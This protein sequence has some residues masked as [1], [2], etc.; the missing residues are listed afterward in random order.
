VL[1]PPRPLG[2]PASSSLPGRRGACAPRLRPSSGIG[3]DRKSARDLAAPRRKRHSCGQGVWPGSLPLRTNLGSG[4]YATR[5]EAPLFLISGRLHLSRTHACYGRKPG[6]DGQSEPAIASR[7]T[8]ECPAWLP[9][10]RR[11]VAA[12][13]HDA[14][15]RH[16]GGSSPCA[17]AGR[18]R[19]RRARPGPG[20]RGVCGRRSRGARGQGRQRRTRGRLLEAVVHPQAAI[21]ARLSPR[22]VT[23]GS[24]HASSYKALRS[25]SPSL[26]PIRRQRFRSPGQVARSPSSATASTRTCLSR[27]ICSADTAHRRRRARHNP[28]T[29]SRVRLEIRR[30]TRTPAALPQRTKQESPLSASTRSSAPTCWRGWVHRRRRRGRWHAVR[31]DVAAAQSDHAGTSGACSAPPRT[32]VTSVGALS[33]GGALSRGCRPYQR[34]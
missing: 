7:Q 2:A 14:R 15:S 33:I 20:Q 6:A 18:R 1:T 17:G 11:L 24:S 26:L 21:R 9:E 30:K 34:A 5:A 4:R 29:R 25:S 12:D 3:N 23:S 22:T 27:G 13:E 19:D 10:P 8:E 28:Q 16:A 31:L 32:R